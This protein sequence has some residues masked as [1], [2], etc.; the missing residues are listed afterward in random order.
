MK[1]GFVG[2]GIMG[3]GMACNLLKAGH[4][5]TVVAHRKRAPVEDLVARGAAEAPSLAALAAANDTLV[6]CVTGAPAARAVVEDLLPHLGPDS[7]IVD[8]TT[9]D[10][11]TP[12]ELAARLTSVGAHYVEAPVAGGVKQAADGVL[13]AIVGCEEA[14]FPRAEAVLTAFCRQVERFGPVGMGARTKLVSNFLALGTA[15][16]VIEAFKLA[17]AQGVDWRKL[18]EIAQLGSG[19]SAG[20][21]RIIGNAL[22]GDYGG[23]V[24]TVDN[25]VKDMSYIARMVAESDAGDGLAASFL[26]IFEAAAAEGHG[27]RLI[28]ELLDPALAR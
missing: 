9:N 10:M 7:L 28:S 8:T 14:D 1:I 20:L 13:G 3:H 19:N 27:Q 11:D 6:L 2:V 17:R 25:T 18:Y 16:L 21:K 4:E 15:T 24:F 26:A 12:A 5:L 22:E 23:Y